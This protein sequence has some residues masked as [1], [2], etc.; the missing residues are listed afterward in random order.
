MGAPWFQIKHLAEDAGLVALSANFA[1]YGDMSDRMMSLAAGLGPHQEVYSIDESFIDLSGMRGDLVERSSVKRTNPWSTRRWTSKSTPSATPPEPAPQWAH[2]S[3]P[4]QARMR[5]ARGVSAGDRCGGSA[6]RPFWSRRSSMRRSLSLPHRPGNARSGMTPMQ[7]LNADTIDART[8]RLLRT[9]LDTASVSRTAEHLGMSQPTVSRTVARLRDVLDDPLL[10]RTR[11]GYALTLRAQALR[12]LVEASLAATEALLAP[13]RFEAGAA[14]R[15]FRVATTDYGALTV[16][17]ATT[18]QFCSM[19]PSASLDVVPFTASTLRELEAGTLDVALWADAALPPDFH[20]RRLFTETYSC[21]VAAGHP[22]TRVRARDV[23]RAMR[24]HE[25]LRL[26]FPNGESLGEDDAF[27]QLDLGPSRVAVR[28]AYFSSAA[29]M[30]AQTSLVMCA[31]SRMASLAAESHGL[32]ALPLPPKLLS[33]DYRA[34]WHERA[35][36]D[37]ANKWLRQLITS[38]AATK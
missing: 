6:R 9:L 17:A 11:A 3:T 27:E 10:V 23:P 31:P 7:K 14:T 35:H 12:P 18:A 4:A 2:A 5:V 37:G 36:R 15:R 16:V 22:L 26:L 24:D 32:T 1:L 38:T 33:F 20:F 8:L 19:A 13:A 28:T 21:L 30:I 34:I 29:A 25:Q